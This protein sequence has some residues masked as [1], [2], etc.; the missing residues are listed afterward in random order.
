MC[1]VTV[2]PPES[3]RERLVA[4]LNSG[5]N[6]LIEDE[7]KHK[8][9]VTGLNTEGKRIYLGEFDIDLIYTKGVDVLWIIEKIKFE[10]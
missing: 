1:K 7:S 5:L 9:V 4:T 6:D 2:Y 10:K 3:E 8:I